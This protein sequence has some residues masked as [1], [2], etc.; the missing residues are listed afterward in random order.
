ML[1]RISAPHFVA[2]VVLQDDVVVRAAPIV[3]YM[4]TNKWRYWRVFS[5]CEEKGWS[6][7]PHDDHRL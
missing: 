6:I 1:I 2:G 7:E 5:Y 4:A 3:G